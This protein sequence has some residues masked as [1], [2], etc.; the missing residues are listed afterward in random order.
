MTTPRRIRR[1]DEHKW[2]AHALT[3]SAV[4]G[5]QWWRWEWQNALERRYCST[6]WLQ[7]YSTLF[8]ETLRSRNMHTVLGNKKSIF[9]MCVVALHPIPFTVATRA[10]SA[11]TDAPCCPRHPSGLRGQLQG[12]VVGMA[13]GVTV[14]RPAFTNWKYRDAF[15]D[16]AAFALSEQKVCP[17][18]VRGGRCFSSTD[19]LSEARRPKLICNPL[20]PPTHRRQP[21]L[22]RR[23]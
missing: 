14:D 10:A 5:P 6:N 18:P 7:P 9:V 8:E 17:W 22:A 21:T 2:S 1:Y 11:H 4:C 15:A 20:P 19:T 3:P 23:T 13:I 12:L 16:N